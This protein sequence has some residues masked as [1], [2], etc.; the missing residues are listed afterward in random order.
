MSPVRARP[1]ASVETQT[2][3]QT[4]L[5]A[6]SACARAEAHG[7]AKG[8]ECGREEFLSVLRD[9]AA[10]CRVTAD[11]LL[12]ASPRGGL[13]CGVCAQACR[14]CAAACRS[15]PEDAQLRM[16]AQLCEAAAQSCRRL[17]D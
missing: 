8:G 3:V 7:L 14:Q 9:C 11:I 16:C 15:F 6:L 2:C 1:A 4:C 13:L 5:D 12:S 10:L 17:A